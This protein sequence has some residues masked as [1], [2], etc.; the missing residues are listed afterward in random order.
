[1]LLFLVHMMVSLGVRRLWLVVIMAL[2][3]SFGTF[4]VF[5]HWLKVPLP[6][7]AFGV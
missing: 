7:G 2:G 6:I 5:Y 1:M 3:G 4:H